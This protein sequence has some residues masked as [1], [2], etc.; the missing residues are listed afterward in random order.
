MLVEDRK[1]LCGFSK[2]FTQVLRFSFW[3]CDRNPCSCHRRCI[4]TSSMRA[5]TW[6]KTEGASQLGWNTDTLDEHVFRILLFQIDP[7]RYKC[8]CTGLHQQNWHFIA[9]DCWILHFSIWRW[10]LQQQ[11]SNEWDWPSKYCSKWKQTSYCVGL[12]GG[13]WT[14]KIH[15]GQ[16]EPS[17]WIKKNTGRANHFITYSKKLTK[18]VRSEG[19]MI[20]NVFNILIVLMDGYVWIYW[21]E[22]CWSLKFLNFQTVWYLQ[23]FGKIIVDEHNMILYHNDE[24]V[25]IWSSSIVVNH[26]SFY[27]CCTLPTPRLII[28][29]QIW[30][31]HLFYILLIIT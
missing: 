30:W 21:I 16:T 17:V 13:W 2:Q 14:A 25:V 11:Y 8:Y 28:T 10:W 15:P 12:Y 24:S 18:K 23:R 7:Y 31:Y 1:L 27:F 20:A 19:L 26:C 22:I 3:N 6:P 9:W 4:F 5:D 29:K